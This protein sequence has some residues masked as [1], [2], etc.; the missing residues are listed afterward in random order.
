M[1][2]VLLA[3]TA[4]LV[5]ALRLAGSAGGETSPELLSSQAATLMETAANLLAQ[6]NPKDAIAAAKQARGILQN[7][8]AANPES[9]DFQLGLAVGDLKVG[10]ILQAQ[11]DLAGALDAYHESHAVATVL[12]QKDPG[13]TP[14]QKALGTAACV[15][16]RKSATDSGMKSATDSDLISAIPI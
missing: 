1:R 9:T 7:L 16:R 8:V 2:R 5:I 14:R 13:A 12:A 10:Y 11:G 3:A 6:G 15:F 4:G